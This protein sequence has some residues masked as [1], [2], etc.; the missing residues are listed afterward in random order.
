MGLRDHTSNSAGEVSTMYSQLRED[1]A[2]H[3]VSVSVSRLT[4]RVSCLLNGISSSTIPSN[5]MMI[6]GRLRPKTVKFS[7]DCVYFYFLSTFDDF[8]KYVLP[9]RVHNYC[10][11]CRVHCTHCP[12]A[13]SFVSSVFLLLTIC[14]LSFQF[15]ASSCKWMT[16]VAVMIL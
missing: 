15:Y 9:S 7:S 6:Y 10:R 2:F 16:I 14:L 8:F 11:V 5:D 3:N 1:E 4:M 13:P 12:W